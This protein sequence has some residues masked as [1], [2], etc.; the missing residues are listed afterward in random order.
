MTARV[1][2]E[3]GF[4]IVEAVMATG[5]TAVGVL[6]VAALM[7]VGTQMQASSRM[8]S[9]AWAVATAEMERIRLL[10]PTQAE[11][12]DGGSLTAN[13]A[14]HWRT[15][16]IDRD[17]PARGV[18]TVRWEIADKPDACAPVGGIAGA[19]LECAKDIRLIAITPN[20]HAIQARIDGVLFR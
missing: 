17:F 20:Q 9:T 11:R 1:A 14:D 13:V 5:I 8:G 18:V 10:A 6:S 16:P 12:A 15:V 4:G 7:M 3:G 2:A 19:L